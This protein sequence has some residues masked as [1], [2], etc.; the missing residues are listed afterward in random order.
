MQES[1]YI[2]NLKL[3]QTNEYILLILFVFESYTI[4][5]VVPTMAISISE[6]E[7]R[8][9]T[10]LRDIVPVNMLSIGKQLCIQYNKYNIYVSVTMHT[11][12]RY[13]LYLHVQ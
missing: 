13:E 12:I 9:T 5:C 7:I 6:P 8:S 2:T 1:K 4:Q 3:G 10:Q 11:G